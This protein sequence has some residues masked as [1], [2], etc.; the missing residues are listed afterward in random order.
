MKKIIAL[1]L[2]IALVLTAVAAFAAAPSGDGDKWNRD[3]NKAFVYD[4]SDDENLIAWANGE[5]ER[6]TAAES[7]Q[8]YFGAEEA[9]ANILG[10]PDY[11][12]NE[13]WPVYA[14]NYE[15]SMG[16]Q[17][18]K[19]GFATPYEKDATVAVMQG[20]KVGED[21]E[22]KPKMEWHAFTGKVIDDEGMIA[23]LLDPATILRVQ[24]EFALLAIINK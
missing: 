4:F 10:D 13:L 14:A 16:E 7:V 18:I 12:V 2:A 9:I 20:F 22:G 24:E 19:L 6:L 11:T 5:I 8:A 15:E 3:D 17:E 1:V 21:E 23:F